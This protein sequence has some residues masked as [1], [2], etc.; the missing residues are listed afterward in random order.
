[1]AHTAWC[2]VGIFGRVQGHDIGQGSSGVHFF[3]LLL[4]HAKGCIVLGATEVSAVLS[5]RSAG[6]RAHRQLLFLLDRTKEKCCLVHVLMMLGVLFRGL[7]IRCTRKEFAP[8]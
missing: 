3:D 8:Q 2:Y 4:L 6:K 5:V 1:M 7:D